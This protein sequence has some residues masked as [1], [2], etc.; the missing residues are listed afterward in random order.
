MCQR[1]QNSQF[2]RGQALNAGIRRGCRDSF[3]CLDADVVIHPRTFQHAKSFLNKGQPAAINVART[4]LR[5]DAEL[6]QHRDPEQWREVAKKSPWRRDG[7]GNILISRALIEGMR[8][9]DE[10]FY[11]WGGSDTELDKR[12]R[13][14]GIDLVFLHDHG[15][16]TALHQW[17]PLTP[18]RESEFTARNRSLLA[19]P[20]A[21]VQNPG[22][23]GGIVDSKTSNDLIV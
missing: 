8:G 2:S 9:Y 20:S 5:P 1:W 3:A 7:V 16:P 13:E 10:R 19:R 15:G 4:D 14:H 17:H 23:W 6:F 18:T 11:G 12:L 21:F 22:G